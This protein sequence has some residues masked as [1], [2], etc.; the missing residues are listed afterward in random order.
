MGAR[1]WS[2]PS[3]KKSA[4]EQGGADAG[5]EATATRNSS[6]ESDAKAITPIGVQDLNKA[7]TG[8]ERVESLV[9]SLR[10]SA[11]GHALRVPCA[12]RG[13]LVAVSPCRGVAAQPRAC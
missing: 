3:S 6:F 12:R 11:R 1:T 4:A 8:T 5:Q 9:L 7:L 13:D 10:A 2:S